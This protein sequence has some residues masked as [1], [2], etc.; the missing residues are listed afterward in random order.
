MIQIK[1]VQG[2]K[3][4][5]T[6]KAPLILTLLVLTLLEHPHLVIPLK[7]SRGGGREV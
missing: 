6:L 2:T 7:G 4:Q 5:K 3:N 1:L